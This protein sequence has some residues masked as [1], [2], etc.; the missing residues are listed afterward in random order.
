MEI[1]NFNTSIKDGVGLYSCDFKSRDG[2]LQTIY[3]EVSPAL[4]TGEL[5]R[6]DP[7]AL[8]FLLLAIK[9][10]ENLI[11][12]TPLSE[13]L[14]FN[15]IHYVYPIFK[16]L[17]GVNVELNIK[18]E[19]V[20][21]DLTSTNKGVITGFSSGVDSFTVFNDHYLNVETHGLKITHLLFNDVG[22]HGNNKNNPVFTKRFNR[23]KE[24][25][26]E[27]GLP[28]ITVSSNVQEILNMDFQLTHTVRNASVAHLF[29]GVCSTFLYASTYSYHDVKIEKTYDMAYADPIL[30][31]LFS[32][33]QLKC[34][35]AGSQYSRT[36]KTEIVAQIPAA[37][38]YLDICIDTPAEGSL[39]C[40]VCSKC[41]R[42]LL[43][44]EILGRLDQFEKVFDL[45][46]YQKERSDFLVEIL[47]SDDP[48]LKE[49]V[50]L[51]GTNGFRLG[52]SFTYRGKYMLRILATRM[53]FLL[54]KLF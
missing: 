53:K 39:N 40:S 28:L 18:A 43:T 32:S 9:N 29:N 46:K 21:S 8:I 30:L 44:L 14:Y 1:L 41:K 34:V 33:D 22:S 26:S 50:E 27:T 47:R 23:I 11:F 15:I 4:D 17:L 49:I 5:E 38:R 36:R 13:S 6:A 24:F 12:K 37:T 48:L 45:D 3:Y 20:C 7:F 31:P 2:V 10:G 51:A 42:T 19:N 16:I 35:S 54:K 25:S 52:S